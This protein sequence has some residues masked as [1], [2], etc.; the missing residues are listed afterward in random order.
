MKTPLARNVY[1]FSTQVCA[2]T[3]VL[4]PCVCEWKHAVEKKGA[5][6][7]LLMALTAGTEGKSKLT[8][9]SNTSTRQDRGRERRLRLD[10]Q[11]HRGIKA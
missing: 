7:Y 4:D 2:H 6:G 5:A 10:S 8:H 11:Q 3:F 9:V 1:G